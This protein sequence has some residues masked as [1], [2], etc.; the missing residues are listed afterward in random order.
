MLLNVMTFKVIDHFIKYTNILSVARILKRFATLANVSEKLY[1][2]SN[3]PKW[4]SS[5]I[6][7]HNF[8]VTQVQHTLFQYFGLR[9]PKPRSSWG[10]SNKKL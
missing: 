4:P 3:W 2:L 10:T 8:S 5:T 1:D 7:S 9:P 6:F